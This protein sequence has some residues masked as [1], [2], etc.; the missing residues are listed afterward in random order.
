MKSHMPCLS[1]GGALSSIQEELGWERGGLHSPA[2][3]S[4]EGSL[5]D[6]ETASHRRAHEHEGRER[7]GQ[8]RWHARSCAWKSRSLVLLG[9]VA[10]LLIGA[11]AQTQ[12]GGA[13]EPQQA[14]FAPGYTPPLELNN[15]AID[16]IAPETRTFAR[17]FQVKNV[18]VDGGSPFVG[19]GAPSFT[20][21]GV[22]M[23]PPGRQ[24]LVEAA[25]V[26]RQARTASGGARG[27]PLGSHMKIRGA[28]Q[29]W[30]DR[31]AAMEQALSRN[32]THTARVEL[33]DW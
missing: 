32:H 24:N 14:V 13:R 11:Q 8:N 31:S 5:R 29:K 9:A 15:Q 30:I 4:A 3:C 17:G 28:R 12:R 23:A 22:P 16:P 21:I 7:G 27:L 6:D 26:T 18:F 1:A 25:E 10:V 2:A 20:A 33:S 19:G